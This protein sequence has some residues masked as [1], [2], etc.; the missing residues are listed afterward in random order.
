MNSDDSNNKQNNKDYQN[1]LHEKPAEDLNPEIVVPA[2][3]PARANEV[4][5]SIIHL[6]PVASRPF[7]P[8]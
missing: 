8:G 2:A 5:P 7:F 4:L 6:L 1:P 3:T